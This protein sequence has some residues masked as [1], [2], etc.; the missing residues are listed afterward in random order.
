M[1]EEEARRSSMFECGAAVCYPYSACPILRHS[2][3]GPLGLSVRM[4]GHRVCQHSDCLRRLSHTPPVSVPPQPHESSPPW[5]PSPP[6]LPVWMCLFSISLVSVPLAV[7][8]SVSSGCV[9][10]YA[11]I[12]V[13]LDVSSLRMASMAHFSSFPSPKLPGALHMVAA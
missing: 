1:R 4:W 7:R 5:C 13:P 3:S 8:F 11:A 6:L 10:T 2:E 12:L 9:S